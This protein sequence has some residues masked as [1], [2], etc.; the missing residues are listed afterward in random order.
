MSYDVLRPVRLIPACAGT[1]TPFWDAVQAY[2]AHPRLRGDYDSSFISKNPCQGS[3]PPARGLL[4]VLYYYFLFP[5]LIPACAGTTS[6]RGFCAFLFGAHPR[7][8]G[9]YNVIPA[10]VT[11]S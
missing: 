5:R 9:D 11:I 6:F 7:L 8:R 2:Q 1:T 4:L 10:A 3:S